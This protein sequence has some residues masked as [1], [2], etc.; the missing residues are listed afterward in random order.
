[1]THPAPRPRGTKT[2]TKP[3]LTH[4]QLVAQMHER[5]LTIP[6]RDR[7]LRYVKQIGYY[8]LSPYMI[9]VRKDGSDDFIS[10]VE[11]D[12]I[13]DLYVFDR[14][15]RL[16]VLDALERAEV[17]IRAAMTDQ[18]SLKYGAF[19]YT[20][21]QLFEDVRAHKKF[22]AWLR[23]RCRQQLSEKP[24]QTS[25][26]LN[27]RSALEH[28]LLTYKRPE[29]PPSWI[30]MELSTIGQL[31]KLLENL[32]QRADVTR[33]ASS[34]GINNQLLISWLR[35]FKRVRNIC[36]HHSRLWNTVLGTYPAIPKSKNVIW[37][38]D[39]TVFSGS[40]HRRYRLYPVLVALQ[41]IM[42]GISPHSS[43]ARRLKDLLDAHPRVPVEA[44]GMPTN[45][46]ADQFWE[47]ALAEP[48]T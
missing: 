31:Q 6:D 3:P 16:H 24:E 11:F 27:H 25:G 34:L 23:D 30:M 17:A 12:Q 29:L 18:M 37:L 45:W 20:E 26:R 5:G 2:Y 21:P 8:R 35:A 7:A 43:W 13:L 33:I 41:S 46:Y 42:Y 15:L 39:R 32:D 14:K 47:R 19:W 22:L 48:S 38:K 40:D 36:A 28:Y 10:G 4:E 1:M 44:M 9:P